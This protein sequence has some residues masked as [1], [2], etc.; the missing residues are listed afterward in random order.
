MKIEGNLSI[1]DIIS[2]HFAGMFI[3]IIG[4]FL[5]YYVTPIFYILVLNTPILILTAI[6][7]WSPLFTLLGINHAA[8]T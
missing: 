8:K 7:G 6:L 4:G 2:R 5:G 3:A 1:T